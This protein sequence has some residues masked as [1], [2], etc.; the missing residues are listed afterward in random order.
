MSPDRARRLWCNGVPALLVLLGAVIRLRQWAGAR[1]F[2]IDE[3]YVHESIRSRGFGR[4]ASEPLLEGQSAPVGWLWSHRLAYDLF[5]G[6]ERA[7]RLPELLSGIA[8]LVVLALVARLVLEP[9]VAPVAVAV[10]ALSPPLIRYSN[11]LKPYGFD[12]LLVVVVLLLA[13]RAAATGDRRSLGLLAG[14]GAVAVWCS[15]PVVFVL[16][17]TSAALVLQQVARRQWRDALV[18]SAVLSAW[19]A[20]L[21]VAYVTVLSR[22]R[23]SSVLN[24]YWAYTFPQGKPLTTWARTRATALLDFPLDLHGGLRVAG[25]LL[26]VG[27]VC[28]AVRGRVAGVGA[29]LAVV[30]GTAAAA[31]AVYPLADR[32]A[33]WLVPVVALSLAA[34]F[35]S[36]LEP[37]VPLR[38]GWLGAA[39]AGTLFVTS[40]GLVHGL[41]SLTRRDAIEETRDL[42]A[43]LRAQARPG[44]VVVG[45]VSGVIGLD[46]YAPRTGTPDDGLLAPARRVDGACQDRAALVAVGLTSKRVWVVNRVGSNETLPNGPFTALQPSIQTVAHPVARITRPGMYAVLFEPGAPAQPAQGALCVRYEPGGPGTRATSSKD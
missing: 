27:A 42:L 9:A 25:L 3:L 36:R 12:V 45:T 15:N 44:D 2:W 18:A 19:V 4:L 16:G 43:A 5:G 6:G 32:L 8:A 41:G 7:Q 23:H 39:L 28:L 26:A 31:A 14:V 10:A 33:L 21:A 38:L 1:S 37:R 17:A 24:D 13:A 30:L 35:P 40:S 34:V 29:V 46:F 22:S 20:S 11:E